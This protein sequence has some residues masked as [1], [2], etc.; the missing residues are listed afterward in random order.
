MYFF[1]LD[2]Q[3][4]LHLGAY[5]VC[6]LVDLLRRRSM[7]N[8]FHGEDLTERLQQKV[9]SLIASRKY[10]SQVRLLQEADSLIEDMRTIL[11]QLQPN[12]N[13]EKILPFN[14]CRVRL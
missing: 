7:W 13:R 11:E 4:S 9:A 2:N 6:Q 10:E 8:A 5:L 3:D 12:R 1:R 14:S